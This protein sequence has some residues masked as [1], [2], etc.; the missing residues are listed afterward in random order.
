LLP[1]NSQSYV[2]PF[3]AKAI[4][5]KVQKTVILPAVL[6]EYETWFVT[7]REE[8]RLSAFENNAEEYWM[9][10]LRIRTS[11][12]PCENNDEPSVWEI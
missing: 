8:C 9:H 2:F 10:S 1:F 3:A 5:I 4:G 11:I 7:Y 12:G 6:Y